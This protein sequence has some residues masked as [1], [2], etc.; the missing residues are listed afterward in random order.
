MLHIS[1]LKASVLI[2]KKLLVRLSPKEFIQVHLHTLLCKTCATYLKQSI[3]I[4]L[5]LSKKYKYIPF[6]KI[7]PERNDVLKERIIQHLKLWQ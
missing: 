1:C 6:D 3:Q 2:E 5:F 7:V 4:E